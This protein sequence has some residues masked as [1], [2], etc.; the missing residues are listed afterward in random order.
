MRPFR[1]LSLTLS[2]AFTLGIG[3]AAHADPV[4]TFAGTVTVGEGAVAPGSAANYDFFG[5]GGQAVN[6][7]SFTVNTFFSAYP[8]NGAYSTI[9]AP[10]G[11]GPFTTGTEFN[12]G[13]PETEILTSFSSTS[14]SNFAVYILNGNADL[15]FV[16]D[17]TIGLG[18]NGD[19][20]VNSAA[21]EG[22]TTNQF[23][24][25]NI[26]GATPGDVFNVYVTA[27]TGVGGAETNI[28]GL[29]FGPEAIPPVPEPSSLVL[30]GTGI[31][32]AFGAARRRFKA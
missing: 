4:I 20:P 27:D 7:T 9:T 3:I 23:N 18:A 1:F 26:S 31:L 16:E 29:T 21:L 10:D 17:S 6:L 22:D 25:Y 32:G 30:L 14:A 12:N 8:G 28:G 24:V 11:T 2:A 19:S 13:D 5:E 15:P